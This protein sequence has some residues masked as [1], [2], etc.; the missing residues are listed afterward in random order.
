MSEE[1][2]LPAPEEPVEAPHD[3]PPARTDDDAP[4]VTVLVTAHNEADNIQSCLRAIMAQDFPMERVE[5]LLVDDRSTDETVARALELNLPSLR[6]LHIDEPP[7]DLTARQAALDLGLREARGE[8]VLITDAD[9]RVSREW[10]RELS[11]HMGFRDGAVAAPVI[12]GGNHHTIARYQSIESLVTFTIY[13]V[14]HRHNLKT[15]VLAGNVAVRRSAYIESGG[16]QAVGFNAAEGVALAYVLRQG[17][18]SL[19]YLT[20]PV[21]Q[22]SDS[23]SFAGLI[24]RGRRKARAAVPWMTAFNLLLVTTNLAL[25]TWVLLGGTHIVLAMLVLG[26]RYWLGLLVFGGA[27]SQYR[28]YSSRLSL[29]LYEPL[30]TYVGTCVYLS[31]IFRP[32]WQ[33]GNISYG[34]S[35]PRKQTAA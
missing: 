6:V 30:L 16:F 26:L 32:Q 19:R 3:A 12:Y 33:W 10:I 27:I 7:T 29:L 28:A 25:L 9:G 2:P 23:G 15:G 21:V 35:G 31:L 5:I 11:G 24:R 4:E 13:R 17:G 20:D 8:I 34:R 18:W 1:T 14:L 22:T